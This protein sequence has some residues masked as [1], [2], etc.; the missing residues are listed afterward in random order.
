MTGVSYF[1]LLI[2]STCA[3]NISDVSEIIASIS[4][5]ARATDNP[6]PRSVCVVR[7]PEGS[8]RIGSRTSERQQGERE[9]SVDRFRTAQ[10]SESVDCFRTAQLSVSFIFFFISKF[11]PSISHVKGTNYLKLLI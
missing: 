8:R 5:I 7:V 1:A 4:I 11:I 2:R 6:F 3:V 10:L 9:E